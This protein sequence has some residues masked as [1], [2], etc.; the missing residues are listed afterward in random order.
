[1]TITLRHE[2]PQDIATIESVTA[3]AFLN[4]EHTEHNEH[5]IVNALRDAG[6]L[7]LSL[8]ALDDQHIGAPHIVGHA[9]ISP[10]TISGGESG[11]YGLAPVS[12]LP[13]FQGKGIGS[14]LVKQILVELK[15]IGAAGCVV[16]G[17]PV[18]YSRFGFVAD[19][20][21]VLPGVPA[22]YF[23]TLAFKGQVPVGTVE[24][25]AAFSVTS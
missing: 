19:D 24:F 12:V 8:V 5:L 10:V 2:T 18:F 15:S 25:H 9:S 3:S 4:A 11:W 20:S 14:A 7:T 22:E 16:L 21:L 1:M 6:A 17:D 13:D 23:Q